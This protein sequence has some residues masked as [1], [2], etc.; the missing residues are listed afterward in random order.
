MAKFPQPT[1]DEL[2][3]ANTHWQAYNPFWWELWQAWIETLLNPNN[4]EDFSAVEEAINAMLLTDDPP[5]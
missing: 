1:T 4:W 3:H 5:P 2:N